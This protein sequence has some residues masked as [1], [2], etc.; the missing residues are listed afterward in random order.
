V[1]AD[2]ATG[3]A[4]EIVFYWHAAIL[5]VDDQIGQLSAWQDRLARRDKTSDSNSEYHSISFTRSSKH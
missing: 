4:V 1:R 3:S 5:Q 2:S